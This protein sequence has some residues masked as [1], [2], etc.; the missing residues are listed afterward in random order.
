MGDVHAPDQWALLALA[1]EAMQVSANHTSHAADNNSY[2]ISWS[3]VLKGILPMLTIALGV[4]G[5]YLMNHFFFLMTMLSEVEA[6]VPGGVDSQDTGSEKY[7]LLE[8]DKY[9]DKKR[10]LSPTRPA[11]ITSSIRATLRHLNAEAGDLS[12]FRG[13]GTASA[14]YLLMMPLYLFVEFVSHRLPLLKKSNRA[15]EA[16]AHVTVALI[17]SQ[18]CATILHVCISKPR[19]KFWFRRMPMTWFKVLRTAWLAVLADVL[20]EEI[21]QAAFYYL[22]PAAKPKSEPKTITIDANN[23]SKQFHLSN[24]PLVKISVAIILWACIKSMLRSQIKPVIRLVLVRPFEAIHNRV[25]A[26]MLPDDEDP[27]IPMDRSFQ[28][29]PQSGGILQQQTQ[30]LG[31]VEAART[32]DKDTYIRLVKL[33]LKLYVI[34]QLVE[35]AFWTLIFAEIIFFVGPSAVW[36]VLKLITGTTVVQ[37]DLDAVHGNATRRFLDSMIAGPSNFTSPTLNM[38]VTSLDQ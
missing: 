17:W 26:S 33:K 34:K 1:N 18:I 6:P 28:G 23:P 3:M 8:E 21:V 30:P 2:G 7:G 12:M 19:Y 37:A 4:V 25:Y 32:I 22:T 38:T 5:N 31:F 20:S 24:G 29:R 27:V 16:F 14:G 11:Y 13:I 15:V 9:K 36:V 35:Y 10:S